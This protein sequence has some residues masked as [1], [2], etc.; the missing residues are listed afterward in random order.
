MKFL[1]YSLIVFCLLGCNKQITVEKAYQR[2]DQFYI[3]KLVFYPDST[4]IYLLMKNETDKNILN[5]FSRGYWSENKD[6]KI[7]LSTSGDLLGSHAISSALTNLTGAKI[8]VKSRKRISLDFEKYSWSKSF[9]L[10]TDSI[11]APELSFE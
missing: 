2:S 11:S 9:K 5:S 8:K 10:T 1:I 4:F 6:G 7:T 3:E